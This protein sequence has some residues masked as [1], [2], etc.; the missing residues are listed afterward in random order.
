MLIKYCFQNF[1][2]V[3]IGFQRL[4]QLSVT[5]IKATVPGGSPDKLKLA[6]SMK[7][8]RQTGK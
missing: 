6:T 7:H 8:T 2:A 4:R 5:F 3:E 1:K